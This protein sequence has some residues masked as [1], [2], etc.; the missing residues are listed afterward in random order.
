MALKAAVNLKYVTLA[1]SVIAVFISFG[2]LNVYQKYQMLNKK[3]TI[4]NQLLQNQ[5]SEMIRKYDSVYYI[6][7]QGNVITVNK[8]IKNKQETLKLEID[9]NEIVDQIN[10]LKKSITSD[11]DNILELKGKVESNRNTLLK[12]QSLRKANKKTNPGKLNAL[13]VKARGVKILSNVY[14][15]S[16]RKKIQEIRVCFT[17]EANEFVLPGNKDI[18]IQ[19]INPEN[20]VISIDQT[21]IEQKG[22]VL[23]YSGYIETFY[24]QKDT[25]VCTYIPLEKAK[26]SK[27]TYKINIFNKFFKIG[28]T[29]FQYN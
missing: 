19:V 15:D 16:K 10:E 29:T 25:D 13:N 24:N 28:T 2:Y 21:Y 7:E 17:L 26:V 9:N 8:E 23:H 1:A 27:G 14:K 3:S 4:E 6:L 20:E 11:E 12:L 22:I 5:L 18:Y